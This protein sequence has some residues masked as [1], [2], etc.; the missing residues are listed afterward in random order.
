MYNTTKDPG[1]G[2]SMGLAV[3][4]GIVESYGGKIEVQSAPGRGSV[5]RIYLPTA[6]KR[7][8]QSCYE[9]VRLPSGT[10]HILF[11]DDEEAIVKMS[12]QLLQRLGYRVTAVTSSLEA[13][14]LFRS[15]PDDFDLVVTDTTMPNMTGDR[16]AVELMKI[17]ADIP[18]IL[19]SG[20]SKRVSDES[21]AKIGIRAFA[22]K[23]I[24][25]A[26]LAETVRK[27]LDEARRR[28]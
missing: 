11:V 15:K 21:A 9:P 1:E 7:K 24:V 8:S 18:I 19:C 22:Y 14:E 16:L 23:P 2:T 5:F 4:H 26:D 20:Y 3:V 6:G 28:R 17:R 25:M 10:E 27:V 12:G 13:V